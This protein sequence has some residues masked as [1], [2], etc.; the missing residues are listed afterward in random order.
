MAYD[1]GL[2]RVCLKLTL[3][4]T[5]QGLQILRGYGEQG[6]YL[7]IMLKWGLGFRLV[8]GLKDA[9]EVPGSRKKDVAFKWVVVNLR[10]PFWVLMTIQ[11]LIFG[12]PKRGP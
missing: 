6:V 1:W 4:N 9:R 10:V 8:F 3:G 11:H 12:V 2:V 5:R 7:L